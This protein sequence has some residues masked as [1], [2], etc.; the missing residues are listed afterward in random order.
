MEIDFSASEPS[1]R[2]RI[3]VLSTTRYNQCGLI[4]GVPLLLARSVDRK[5]LPN[6]KFED[7]YI[8]ADQ[9]QSLDFNNRNV[10]YVGTIPG[11]IL[12]ESLAIVNQILNTEVK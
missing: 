2:V 11:E 12:L 7:S 4:L 10:K 5:F 6:V 8:L 1:V 9:V 3:L